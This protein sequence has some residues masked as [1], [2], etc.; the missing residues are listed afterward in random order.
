MAVRRTNIPS[1]PPN[2]PFTALL[3]LSSSLTR[4][5]TGGFY[6]E[7]LNCIFSA[8]GLH[9]G[10]VHEV[11][12][13]GLELAAEESLP[14][15]MR[16]HIGSISS[17]APAWFV[18]QN[19]AKRRR[20]IVEEDT[21]TMFGT[22]VSAAVLR[23]SGWTAIASAPMMIGR[24]VLGVISIGAPSVEYL[25]PQRIAVLET[26][27]NVMALFIAKTK[28]ATE[29]TPAIEGPNSLSDVDE[30][31]T[32][33][34]TLGALALG[35]ADD[36]R[37]V[38]SQL[39][40]FINHQEKWI[41]QLRARHP[42][43][44]AVIRELEPLQE[45]AA[46]A[47]MVARMSSGRLLAAID[48]NAAETIDVAS[49]VYEVVG[50]V[51]PAARSRNVDVLVAVQPG[52]DPLV[53]GKR[54]EIRQLVLGLVLDGIDACGR[55][56]KPDNPAAPAAQ[57]QM[58]SITVTRDKSK[59]T[60]VVE[61]SGKGSSTEH[62]QTPRL[63]S[64]RSKDSLGLLLGRN[65]VASHSGTLEI[66]RSDL[67]GALVRVVLPAATPPPSSK[68][69]KGGPASSKRS[70]AD[71]ATLEQHPT[72]KR[73]GWTAKPNLLVGNQ[74]VAI[75]APAPITL[76]HDASPLS[77]AD[78]MASTERGSALAAS[79]IPPTP[80]RKGGAVHNDSGVPSVSAP[81]STRRRSQAG[82]PSKRRG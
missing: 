71:M 61:H 32:R 55:E 49:V 40:S 67:G 60:V 12:P 66:T 20:M 35:C 44:V 31:L 23:S 76:A 28:A 34:A 69:S 8:T 74:P 65:I 63:R 5:T 33:L 22:R 3:E 30:K 24:D 50:H 36:L 11:T 16:A 25:S 45:E 70:R 77:E 6:A 29:E 21:T 17:A 14:P 48:E 27:T 62:R 41:E 7:A 73:D 38:S 64:T 81:P 15:A 53:R 79:L 10:V 52:S 4:T 1:Q 78:M 56:D 42:G 82:P 57:M 37:T 43:A 47:L 58:A 2:N 72:T 54:S 13:S 46:S 9:A 59:V 80:R 51:E 39:T 68:R 19:V 18:A 26:V 75:R